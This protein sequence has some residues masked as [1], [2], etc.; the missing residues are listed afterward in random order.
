M[1]VL[2]GPVVQ[3]L[4][5]L[6]I[7]TD[8]DNPAEHE[9]LV[10]IAMAVREFSL[11]NDNAPLPKGPDH[12]TA[13]TPD[14]IS[15]LLDVRE[16]F[17][18]SEV[19]FVLLL[20]VLLALVLIQRKRKGRASLKIPFIVGGAIP[21]TAAAI[22]GIA[23]VIDFGLFFTWLHSIFFA[24]GTWTFPADSLLIRSL[25]FNFWAA[26]AAVLVGSM[27]LLCALSVF[28]GVLLGRLK[29]TRTAP[30]TGAN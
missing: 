29:K 16:V 11:G 7:P 18:A 3:G 26:C 8:A 25:P 24:E 9:Q 6:S 21:L 5:E 17:V 28:I 30:A 27:A 15:H 13:I 20:G 1:V 12:R 23:V 4:A 22:L 19:A 14:A 10:I 2:S